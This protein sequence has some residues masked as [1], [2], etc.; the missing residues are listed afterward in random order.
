MRKT[1]TLITTLSA[2]LLFTGCSSLISSTTETPIKDNSGERTLGSYVEDEIIET[3]AMVNLNKG[4][5]SLR[6][7]SVSVT[8]FNGIVL[9]TGQAPNDETRAEAEAIVKN[10]RKVRKV[11]NEL[12]LSGVSSALIYT[13]DLFLTLRSKSQLLLNDQ[14]PGNRIKVVTD[15]GTVFLMGLVTRDEANKAVE[16][17]STINGVERIVKIFE[18]IN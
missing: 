10:I 13:N 8:S 1:F 7:A 18:Y 16:V 11:H 12:K 15:G 14:A 2:C 5:E 9:L 6:N 3:K 4:S 17:I